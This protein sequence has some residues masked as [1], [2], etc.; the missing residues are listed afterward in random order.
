VAETYGKLLGGHARVRVPASPEGHVF[1]QYTV[2][3]QGCDRDQIQARMAEKGIDT[4][5]Y[6]PVPCHRLTL[7]QQSH[8]HVL[9][10]NAERL[11]SQVISL[12]IWPEM[13]EDL[14]IVVACTLLD[15]L[16]RQ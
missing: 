16:E 10:P 8:A 13:T 14:Q 7:Y 15:L 12:P 2:Q 5:V 6:Y 3:L 4:M 9:C 11:A 1:H